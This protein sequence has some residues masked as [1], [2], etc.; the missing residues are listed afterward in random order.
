MWPNKLF[1]GSESGPHFWTKSNQSQH[2]PWK[3]CD[4]PR[5]AYYAGVKAVE[6][7]DADALEDIMTSAEVWTSLSFFLSR[8]ILQCTL[9]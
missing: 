9:T 5:T 6:S 8:A 3:H 7:G 4:M 2:T 1:L